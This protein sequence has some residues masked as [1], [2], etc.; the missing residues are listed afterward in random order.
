MSAPACT[1]Y[2]DGACP[3][4]RRE[5]AHYRRVAGG[6]QIDWVD[7]SACTPS[8]LGDGLPREAALS[9][10]HV[11]LAD[12]SL[13]S[14]A[15]AFAAIWARLPGYSW[16]AA[17]AARRPVRSAMEFAYAGFLRLR[18]LWRR[19]KPAA[20][21]LP[22]EV[23]DELRTDHAAETGSVQIHRGILALTDDADVRSFAARRLAIEHLH[24][25]RIR[26]WLPS[27]ERSRLLPVWRAAG[28]LTGAVAGLIGP[29]AVFAAVAA[30]ERYVDRRYAAQ[31]DRLAAHPQLTELRATLAACRS[32]EF[33]RHDTQARLRARCGLL[34]RGR[35]VVVGKGPPL[36]LA[37]SRRP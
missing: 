8:A 29:R 18:P 21:A 22:P 26:R 20:A 17:F 23:I 30:I 10:L 14:G 11:R 9:R 4:C 37:A 3:V 32:D 2:F 15:A 31:I 1:V 34:G 19:A 28:W 24:L 12:G 27:D 6:G 13:V 35:A 16:L 36:A 25:R 33:D 7:A 5:I